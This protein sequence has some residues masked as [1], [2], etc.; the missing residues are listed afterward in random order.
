MSP[1]SNTPQVSEGEEEHESESAETTRAAE[2]AVPAPVIDR[3]ADLQYG[4]REVENRFS[5]W[6]EKVNRPTTTEAGL[7][8]PKTLIIKIPVD[9]IR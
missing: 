8:I 1:L 3:Y 2:D 5:F 7:D 4:Q 6:F 9:I